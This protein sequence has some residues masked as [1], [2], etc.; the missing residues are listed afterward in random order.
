[1]RYT[2]SSLRNF[3]HDEATRFKLSWQQV[4]EVLQKAYCVQV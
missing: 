2:P 4:T 1:M 3:Y